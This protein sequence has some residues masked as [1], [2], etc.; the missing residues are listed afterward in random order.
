VTE[1]PPLREPLGGLIS[2]TNGRDL[3]KKEYGAVIKS[4]E[5]IENPTSTTPDACD[6]VIHWTAVL[7][8]Y[9]AAAHDNPNRQNAVDDTKKFRPL[10][11][12]TVFPWLGP[13]R[14]EISFNVNAG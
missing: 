11:V 4:T 12:R 1:V 5:L 7:F 13:D 10:R 3:N 14:G 6:G 8:R 2:T 9:T